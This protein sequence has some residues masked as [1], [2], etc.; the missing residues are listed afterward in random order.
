[1]HCD[2]E[3]LETPFYNKQYIDASLMIH[4]FNGFYPLYIIKRCGFYAPWG[5]NRIFI[6]NLFTFSL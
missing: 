2:P 4:T 1:M 5:K 6:S 3:C